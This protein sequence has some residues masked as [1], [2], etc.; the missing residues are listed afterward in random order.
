MKALLIIPLLLLT[1]CTTLQNAVTATDNVLAS[2]QAKAIIAAV[3]PIVAEYAA[4][5]HVDQAQAI[6]VG[7]QSISLTAGQQTSTAVLAQTIAATVTQFTGDTKTP[8]GQKIAKA[9]IALIPADAQPADVSAAIVAA[10]VGAS[11]GANR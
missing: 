9:V 10:G 4:T 6:N 5:G 7:L 11:N 3:A 8:V 1:S 2:P